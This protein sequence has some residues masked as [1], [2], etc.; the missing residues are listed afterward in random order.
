MYCH[1]L[2]DNIILGISDVNDITYAMNNLSNLVSKK[3]F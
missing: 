1:K 2:I 3:G